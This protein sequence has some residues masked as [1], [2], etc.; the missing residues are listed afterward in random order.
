MG[1]AS[2]EDKC[3]VVQEVERRIKM[4]AHYDADKG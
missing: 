3:R 1:E 4:I 2:D